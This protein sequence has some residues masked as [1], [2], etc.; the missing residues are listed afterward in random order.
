M[1]KK[2]LK[3]SVSEVTTMWWY[4]NRLFWYPDDWCTAGIQVLQPAKHLQSRVKPMD[5]G[6]D[7]Q[8]SRWDCWSR[9]YHCQRHNG[10]VWRLSWTRQQVSCTTVQDVQ[11]T[12]DAF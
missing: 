6:S 1:V 2:I 7:G 8:L 4:R 10:R 5:T 12:F 11:C 3:I 9:R